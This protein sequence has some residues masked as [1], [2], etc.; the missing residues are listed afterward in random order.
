MNA[1]SLYNQFAIITNESS[2]T[3]LDRVQAALQ[4]MVDALQ[5]FDVPHVGDRMRE[6]PIQEA[7]KVQHTLQNLIESIGGCKTQ[8]QKVFDFCRFTVIPEVMEANDLQTVKVA[9]VGRVGL[10]SDLNVSIKAGMKQA[11]Y[12]YLDDYG[13]GDLI[14]NTVNSS[15]LKALAKDY[16]KKGEELPD[17]IFN[18]SPFTRATITK[19]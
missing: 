9:G 12:E 4:V 8:M 15:S 3:K 16:F 13:H 18:V 1:Q 7:A 19:G 14:I 10:T 6:L 5:D 17:E 11:A 2:T